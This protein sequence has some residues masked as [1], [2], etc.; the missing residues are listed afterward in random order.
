MQHVIL[1]RYAEI[2][3]KGLNRPYFEKMLCA[4]IA[5]TI[6]PFGGT[7]ERTQGR[8]VVRGFGDKRHEAMAMLSKVFGIQG[9]CPA[10]EIDKDIHVI[11]DRAVQ[12]M[13]AGNHTTCTFKVDARRADKSFPMDSMTIARELGGMLLERL[14]E[15]RV[16]VHKP[17]V[18]V[19]VEIREQA[20]VYVDSLPGPGGMP[21]GC[22]GKACLLLSGGID[23]PVAGWMVAKRGVSLEAV[24]FE[25][26]PYTSERARDK[27]VTL[28]RML[29]EWGTPARLHVVPF[30][31]IQR[32]LYDKGPDSQLT[33]L[34][35]RCMMRIAEEIALKNR[36]EERRVGKEC[37]SRWSPYH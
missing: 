20:Y 14:P 25:S 13:E 37:R 34:M 1:V 8:M 2:H 29:Q 21:T 19:A 11:A 12:L 4:R 9:L 15:L 36:S 16:D 23:S 10:V 22:N 24:H 5:Q 32:Q 28:A 35:R 33:I 30:T 7:V 17:A 3:L 26:P 27:V 18:H 31:D 6:K